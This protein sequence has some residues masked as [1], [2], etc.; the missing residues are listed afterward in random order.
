LP[1]GIADVTSADP[2]HDPRCSVASATASFNVMSP[3][4][5]STAMVGFQ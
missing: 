3:A 4:K 5:E 1:G 2:L